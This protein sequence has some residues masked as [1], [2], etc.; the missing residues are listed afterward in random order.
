VTGRIK[1]KENFLDWFKKSIRVWKEGVLPS[2]T[3]KR[4]KDGR[5]RSVEVKKKPLRATLKGKKG[6]RKKKGRGCS[7]TAAVKKE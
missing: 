7:I 5:R 4:E 3:G 1:K 2:R 6:F